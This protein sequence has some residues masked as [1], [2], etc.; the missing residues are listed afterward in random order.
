MKKKKKA[1]KKVRVMFDS[2]TSLFGDEKESKITI[3]DVD[4][5]EP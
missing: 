1:F 5:V 4:I 3:S 2:H